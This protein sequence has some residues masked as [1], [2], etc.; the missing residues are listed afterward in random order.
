MSQPLSQPILTN[1][2]FL[3]IFKDEFD[4]VSKILQIHKSSLLKEQGFYYPCSSSNWFFLNSCQ[5]RNLVVPE[6]SISPDIY[7]HFK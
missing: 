2:L 1:N 7:E 6:E 4:F 3:V 5:Y